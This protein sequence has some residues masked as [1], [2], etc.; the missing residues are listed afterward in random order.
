MKEKIYYVIIIIVGLICGNLPFG[1]LIYRITH[2]IIMA[3]IIPAFLM[4]L[5]ITIG[6]FQKH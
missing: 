4:L 3:H 2:S 5:C 6:I 1:L